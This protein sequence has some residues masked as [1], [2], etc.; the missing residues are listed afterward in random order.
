MTPVRLAV[1]G[2]GDVAQRDYLPEAHRLG[3]VAEISVL[4]G[5]DPGRVRAVADR[6]GIPAWSTDYDEVLAGEIDA[7]VNLT[8]APAHEDLTR[9]ALRAGRHVYSEKPMALDAARAAR[10]RDEA[11]QRGLT[12]V[13][14]PSILL[15]PQVRLVRDIL[16]SGQLGMIRSARAHALGGI[17]PWEGYDSDPTPFFAA[18]GGPLVDM[19]V[20]PLHALAGLL[21]P[22]RR[23]TAMTARTR[24]HFTV[25]SG[26]RAGQ[27]VQVQDAD[28]WHLLAELGTCVASV[29]AN[30]STVESA[31]AECELRGDQGAVAFSLLDVAAPVRVLRPGADGWAELPVARER[32]AGPDHILGVVHLAECI[33]SGSEP[34]PSAA[35]AIHVLEVIAAARESASTGCA[36]SVQADAHPREQ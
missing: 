19:G 4:C 5:R 18:D 2:A 35:A 20:Y 21:G 36:V 29:E 13:C 7:V 23:V 25:E 15:F 8:P 34:V 30:F 28:Q 9:A 11:A 24:D 16:A 3:G 31:A 10:L 17:P 33:T 27:V 26:P 14:A 22:V 12:L 1:V 32:E 6:F